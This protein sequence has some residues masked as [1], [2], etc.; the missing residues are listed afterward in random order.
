[1]QYS[2]APVMNF[3]APYGD[4]YGGQPHVTLLGKDDQEY[5]KAKTAAIIVSIHNG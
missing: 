5:M 3:V 4:S 2:Q 1:M